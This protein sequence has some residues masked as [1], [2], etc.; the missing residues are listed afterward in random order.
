MPTYDYYSDKTEEVK[1]VFHGMSEE[2]EVLDS[3]GNKM[4]RIISGGT[5]FTIQG[6]GTRRRNMADR[7]GH[8][9]TE[10]Q[11]TPT[12]AAAGKAAAAASKKREKKTN[13]DPYHKV[14]D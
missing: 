6:G 2:P 3:Q 11:A 13:S 7:H 12:E 4:R 14:R 5:G 9:K 8:K 1:E 10:N